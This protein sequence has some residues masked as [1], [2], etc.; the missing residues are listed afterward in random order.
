MTSA[1]QIVDRPLVE[2]VI[3]AIDTDDQ[4]TDEVMYF[5]LAALEGSTALQ[6]LLDGPR[7]RV[8]GRQRTLEQP[9]GTFLTPSGGAGFRGTGQRETLE[10]H[11]ATGITIASGRNGS[12]K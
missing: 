4:L 3:D 2:V 6:E 8:I 7:P 9:V 1:D 12:G 10:P 5:V 11:P